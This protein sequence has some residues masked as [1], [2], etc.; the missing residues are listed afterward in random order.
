MTT[1]TTVDPYVSALVDSEAEAQDVISD[2]LVALIASLWA[3]FAG[4]S[5]ALYAGELVADFGA[6][7]ASYV[8][9]AQRA[10]AQI[11][12]AHLRTGCAARGCEAPGPNPPCGGYPR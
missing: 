11:T 10:V 6:R 9:A 7:V 4:A 1:P 3:S 12:E 5:S 2:N 8:V